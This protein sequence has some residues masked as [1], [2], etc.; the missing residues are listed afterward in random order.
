M[1]TKTTTQITF[2]AHGLTLDLTISTD[3][4]QV[5][6]QIAPVGAKTPSIKA[7]A[8]TAPAATG[9]APKKRGRPRKDVADAGPAAT[10]EAPK[11]RGRPRKV[12][13]DAGPATEEVP[14]AAAPPVPPAPGALPPVPGTE[15]L[16]AA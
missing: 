1:G 2:P 12:V 9:E 7:S 15:D 3:D 5:A 16:A 6:I 10:G 8:A 14:A 4:S 13:A 11:K